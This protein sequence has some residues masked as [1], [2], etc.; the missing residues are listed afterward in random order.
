MKKIM[1]LVVI[2]MFLLSSIPAISQPAEPPVDDMDV[3]ATTQAQT[4]EQQFTSN[5]SPETFNSLPADK[6]NAENLG[7]VPSP[8]ID[9]FQK[10]GTSPNGVAE[11]GKYLDSKYNAEFAN[12]Y[13]VTKQN[14]LSAASKA[15]DQFLQEKFSTPGVSFATSPGMKYSSDKPPTITVEGN[16]L[17]SAGGIPEGTTAVRYDSAGKTFVFD[18]RNMQVQ[19]LAQGTQAGGSNVQIQGANMQMNKDGSITFNEPGKIVDPKTNTVISEIGK[20][21]TLQIQKGDDGQ[22]RATV[23][24]QTVGQWKDASGSTNSFDVSVNGKLTI[25]PEVISG[26]EASVNYQGKELSGDFVIGL[27]SNKITHASLLSDGSTLKDNYGTVNGRSTLDFYPDGNWKNVELFGGEAE[28]GAPVDGAKA[29][30]E[31]YFKGECSIKFDEGGKLSSSVIGADSKYINKI[32]KIEVSPSEQ[33]VSIYFGKKEPVEY[34]SIIA[35]AKGPVVLLDKDQIIGNGKFNLETGSYKYTGLQASSTIISKM[36]GNSEFLK[37]GS[38]EDGDVASFIKKVKVGELSSADMDQETTLPDGTKLNNLAA[39][40]YA[41]SDKYKLSDGTEVNTELGMVIKRENGV[42]STSLDSN[43]VRLLAEIDK[44]PNAHALIDKNLI[45]EMGEKNS[46]FGFG[47]GYGMTYA[48]GDKTVN[49]MSPEKVQSEVFGQNLQMRVTMDNS[50]LGLK[51]QLNDVSGTLKEI[52]AKVASSNQ[53]EKNMAGYT[54]EAYWLAA[55]VGEE[56]KAADL[57]GD[58]KLDSSELQ[59]AISGLESS[60]SLS[61]SEQSQLSEFKNRLNVVESFQKERSDN[62][63][64]IDSLVGATSKKYDDAISSLESMKIKETDTARKDMID[65]E[66]TSLKTD[67][68]LLAARQFLDGGMPEESLSKLQ[69]MKTAQGYPE[70]IKD[71]AKF[72]EGFAQLKKGD[73]AESSRIWGELKDT[74]YGITVSNYQADVQ[75]Q[76]FAGLSQQQAAQ[77]GE[78]VTKLDELNTKYDAWY[79]NAKLIVEPQNW[80]LPVGVTY[81][82]YL[83]SSLDYELSGSDMLITGY[84][85]MSEILKA[86]KPDGTRYTFEEIQGMSREDFD[87]A[88]SQAGITENLAMHYASV[89]STSYSPEAQIS[90]LEFKGVPDKQQMA[91]LYLASAQTKESYGYQ[92]KTESKSDYE[93]VIRYADPSSEE[94]KLAKD[95]LGGALYNVQV[96]A[97]NPIVQNAVFTAGQVGATT[98]LTMGASAGLQAAAAG[99]KGTVAGTRIAA[100][101]EGM[102]NLAS[103]SKVVQVAMDQWAN[104]GK[105]SQ[106]IT[107]AGAQTVAGYYVPGADTALDIMGGANLGNVM[108]ESAE[109]AARSTSNDVVESLMHELPEGQRDEVAEAVES[110]VAKYGADPQQSG[111]MADEILAGLSTSGVTVDREDLVDTVFSTSQKNWDGSAAEVT[112]R[113]EMARAVAKMDEA[114]PEIQTSQFTLTGEQMDQLHEEGLLPKVFDSGAGSTSFDNLPDVKV[115]DEKTY[116]SYWRTRVDADTMAY[117]EKHNPGLNQVQ[118]ELSEVTDGI[119]S[120][121][122]SAGILDEGGYFTRNGERVIDKY[123]H[124]IPVVTGRLK[125][126]YK[127]EEKV[128]RTVEEGKFGDNT[129]A[130]FETA[131]KMIYA[132]DPRQPFAMRDIIGTRVTVD[133][134]EQERE[135]AEAL[136]E[137]YGKQGRLMEGNTKYYIDMDPEKSGG[138]RGIH[139]TVYDDA[140]LPVEVQIRTPEQTKWADWSHDDIYKGDLKENV[141]ATSYSKAVSEVIAKRETGQ[142]AVPCDLPECPP[143]LV[144]RELCFS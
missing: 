77:K 91:E 101:T 86:E 144:T 112:S 23:D 62:V 70:E 59:K 126:D 44:D 96:A 30:K 67:Q 4:P 76:I 103:E 39:K 3:T 94:Y 85:D 63:A 53:Q 33:P 47:Q 99:V 8:T 45:L 12:E 79:K 88:A 87:K 11:Q 21:S 106:F 48:Q 40:S 29:T 120:D 50:E 28:F 2:L 97:D 78:Y 105:V 34:N 71:D 16:S 31:N 119:S 41:I 114:M 117:L 141:A 136:I 104:T 35:N 129:P 139:L 72:V 92:G 109:A 46:Y 52:S 115:V 38:K 27:E 84:K 75:A 128:L 60:R 81:N 58:G 68:K 110:A 140:G 134:V 125:S 113:F 55:N 107:T 64:K 73:I 108:K 14:D 10:L 36:D 25:S 13:F 95:K 15:A 26:Q 138:Y 122:K 19:G 18:P 42:V 22:L 102:S 7:K 56:E 69:S 116:W 74:K 100:A 61:S 66:I 24:G 20:G 83:K 32:E 17:S 90:N 121:L 93:N 80:N 98:L 127:I 124:P 1:P 49:Y 118:G 131:K 135:V 54:Y 6:M 142:C 123:G 111:K 57:N 143:V 133:T 137:E 89:K 9:N 5:P 65:K 130:D 82:E 43:G 132:A 37:I 51:Q